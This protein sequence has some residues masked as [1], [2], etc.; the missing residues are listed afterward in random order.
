MGRDRGPAAQR[1]AL[2]VGAIAVALSVL[3]VPPPAPAQPSTRGLADA[4]VD[5]VVLDLAYQPRRVALAIGIDEYDDATFPSLRFAS[6]DAAAFGDL[7]GDPRWGDFDEV[8]ILTTPEETTRVEIL[9]AIDDAV[10]TLQ[11]N[12]T[13][14]LYFSG[15]GS[16]ATEERGSTLYIC[17]RDANPQRLKHSAVSV[18]TLQRILGKLPCR[19]RVMIL[20]S[21]HNGEAKSF[22]AMDTREEIA[23][24]R[25]PVDPRVYTRVGEAEAHL[26][27]AAFHQ[28]ALEDPELGHG[29]YTHYLL[30]ALSRR[31]GSS[32]LDGDG[33][34]TV[35]EA[36]QYARDHTIAYTGG[37][38]VPQ[39][40]F[41]EVGREDI[42]LSGGEGALLVAERGLLV[43][44]SR[45]LADCAISVDGVAR[46]SLPLALSVEPGLH[47]VEVIEPESGRL[48]VQRTVNV[49]AGK[50]LSVDALADERRPEKRWSLAG[51]IGVFGVL[52][53]FGQGYPEVSAGIDL[54]ARRRFQ[55]TARNV[56]L[57]IDLGLSHGKG[58]YE[59]VY[60]TDIAAEM[61]RVGGGI[62]A[63]HD[64]RRA[65]LWIGLQGN[66][67]AVYMRHL[68]DPDAV[69]ERGPAAPMWAVMPAPRLTAGIDLWGPGRLGVQL[70]TYADVFVPVVHDT[71][72]NPEYRVGFL[73]GGQLRLLGRLQ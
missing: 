25:S 59:A 17:P 68:P 43:S 18:D 69:D 37:A 3:A 57:T 10:A 56:R 22:L 14:V 33:V 42:F 46:G 63:C 7:L 60:G 31:S 35:V 2:I 40:L 45:L 44:Y 39:A 67:I 28:P 20:D 23:Q 50:S 9:A 11:R 48:L 54:S 6:K 52:G 64:I 12:D 72:D 55:R 65:N 16:L 53:P 61:L 30:E 38:Q 24:R 13:F 36:H 66:L 71:M 4:P 15:H 49:T 29:V 34:I 70:G 5:P 21:C 32:D 47:R 8:V 51:G 19:R 62:Q 1:I 58:E 26:F 41:K 27:A 73:V